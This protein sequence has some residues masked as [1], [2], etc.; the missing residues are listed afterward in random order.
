MNAERL[1]TPL[2]K[3]RQ[4]QRK[5]YQSAKRSKVRKF[6]ALY[7]KLYREDILCEAW[8]RVKTNGGSAGVDQQTIEEIEDYGVK[9][10][11]EEIQTELKGN[12]YNPPP[13]KRITSARPSR[14]TL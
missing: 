11:V 3:V 12:S 6:H 7:D 5:L 9:K 1:I 8:K 2:D 13:V 10:L 4:L 14:R